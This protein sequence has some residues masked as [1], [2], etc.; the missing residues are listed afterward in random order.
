MNED[1]TTDGGTILGATP[2]PTNVVDLKQFREN[3]MNPT[4]ASKVPTK[5]PW[6]NAT[7]VEIPKERKLLLSLVDADIEMEG[8]IGLTN[9]FLA[10]GDKNGG[11]KF[12]AAPGMWKYVTDVTDVVEDQEPA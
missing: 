9:S 2:A 12:A 8:F 10:I 6:P 3:K 5:G 1:N 4:G 7:A 11:I